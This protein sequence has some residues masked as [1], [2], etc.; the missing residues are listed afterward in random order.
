MRLH[1]PRRGDWVPLLPERTRMLVIMAVPAEALFRSYDYLTPDVDE[2]SSSLTV[3]ERMMPI[4]AWGAVCGIVA[5]VALWGLILRWPR[6][7]IAGF[8]LGG[9]MYTLLA[10][11]QWIAVFHNPWLDG[12]RGAAIVTLFALAYWGLAKGYTDQVRSR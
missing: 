7:A 2:T 1:G 11:G 4:E 6:T 10:A 9:A 8:R 3:V 12:I 5:V